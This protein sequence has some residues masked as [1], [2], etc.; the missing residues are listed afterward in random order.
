MLT[1]QEL[2]EISYEI[3]DIL[4]VLST[5]YQ[6]SPLSLSAITLARLLR[7]VQEVDSD[8]EFKAIMSSAI[9]MGKKED[10]VLQ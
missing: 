3:D 2:T 8:G 1:D 5:K 6:I 4:S 7:L 10:R 9:G